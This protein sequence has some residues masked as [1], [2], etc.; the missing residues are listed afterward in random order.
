MKF[1]LFLL[2][3]VFPF[4]MS[5]VVAK[6]PVFSRV[7]SSPDR[8]TLYIYRPS[9]F[10]AGGRI[11]Q[12]FVDEKLVAKL[13]SNGYSWLKLPP[14]TYTVRSEKEKWFG[15]VPS[16]HGNSEVKVTIESGKNY[17]LRFIVSTKGALMNPVFSDNLHLVDE[18]QALL[19]I[20]ENDCRYQKLSDFEEKA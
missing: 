12:F 5:C 17:Y 10:A 11:F 3:F 4:L 16:A 19:E 14:G 20:K 7:E 15:D 18:R 6:G 2:L 1:K 13:E 8:G 9:S